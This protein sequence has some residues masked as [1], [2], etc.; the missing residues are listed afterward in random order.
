MKT[1][2]VVSFCDANPGS[3]S[4]TGNDDAPILLSFPF[5]VLQSS[6]KIQLQAFEK[7]T[8]KKR[9]FLLDSDFAGVNFQGCNYGV[10]N[11][12]NDFAGFSVGVYDEVTG[13]MQL[14]R[15]G[16]A[17]AMEQV[18]EVEGLLSSSASTASTMTA[19]ERRQSLT[20]TFGSKKKKRAMRAAES[21]IISSHNI[22]AADT[23]SDMLTES[24]ED[25]QR[26][27]LSQQ[28]N[29]FVSGNAGG[30]KTAMDHHREMMLPTFDASAT[31]LQEAY[32]LSCAA[33]AGGGAGGL[34]PRHLVP[35]LADWVDT[36]SSR[37]SS[38]ST[39]EWQHRF[40]QDKSCPKLVQE[41]F[42]HNIAQ[43]KDKKFK[44]AMS[45][46]MLCS[47]MMRLAV[48]LLEGNSKPIV[49][50]TLEEQL[51]SPPPALLRHLTDSF[52]VFKKS[53][54]KQAFVSTKSLM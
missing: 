11:F 34:L 36:L 2:T 8:S 17:Y 37:S 31:V 51:L 13:E 22:V 29:Q 26:E 43:L 18:V 10:N 35:L 21:N 42:E 3:V 20:D 16:H 32:P 47:T 12:S 4:G 54:G 45:L 48:A 28:Q 38:S 1:N 5:G 53:F 40:S 7:A 52:A 19:M 14:H 41:M 24:L 15:V 27:A 23:I 50:E 39:T 9:K 44:K 25:Q 46:L 33:G 30:N 49:K 6:D